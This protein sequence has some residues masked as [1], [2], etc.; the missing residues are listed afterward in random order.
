MWEWRLRQGVIE[1]EPLPIVHHASSPEANW[2]G[3]R[4]RLSGFSS[5][6]VSCSSLCLCLVGVHAIMVSVLVG[7]ALCV[8]S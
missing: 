1:S 5:S 4:Y 7:I 3:S 2:L 6:V 8:S